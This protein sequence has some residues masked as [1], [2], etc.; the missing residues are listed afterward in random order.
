MMIVRGNPK[1]SERN[2]SSATSSSTALELNPGLCT[3]NPT[4]YFAGLIVMRLT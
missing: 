2:L 4:W 1:Y 3:E